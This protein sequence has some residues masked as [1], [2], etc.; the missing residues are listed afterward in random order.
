MYE[1]GLKKPTHQIIVKNAEGI[2]FDHK[3]FSIHCFKNC[4]ELKEI[5]IEFKNKKELFENRLFH[6]DINS[7]RST[8]IIIIQDV[9]TKKIRA[10]N[11][12]IYG[13]NSKEVATKLSK[14]LCGDNYEI[15]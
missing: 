5:V 4:E 3:S 14:Y 8:H 10:V 11:V 6:Y 2:R 13:Y 7:E 12:K 15:E 1:F 9:K